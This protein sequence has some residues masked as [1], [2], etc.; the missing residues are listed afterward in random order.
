MRKVTL[1]LAY[2]Q[3]RSDVDP[4]TGCWVWRLYKDKLG[5]G[6]CH[7]AKDI[8]KMA[9]RVSLTVARGPIP[10]GLEVDHLCRNT[11]CVNPDHLEA[12]TQRENIRRAPLSPAT[13]NAAKTH[14]V[15]GHEFTAS[16]T[17]VDPNRGRICRAC[18]REATARYRSRR[19]TKAVAA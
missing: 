10:D 4:E 7:V 19:H 6:Y 1:D 8:S 12:V 18:Q 3:A 11:S 13:L 14:C 5:Y 16:N 17:R 15:N 2:F 9:H